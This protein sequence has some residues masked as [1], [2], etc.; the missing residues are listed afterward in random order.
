MCVDFQDLNKACPK[1]CYPLP[2]IDQMV[3]STSEYEILCFMDAYQGYHHID[4]AREDQENVSFI[5][6]GGTFVM[7]L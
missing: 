4:L 6:S 2:H 7:L 1:D 5:T 3:D